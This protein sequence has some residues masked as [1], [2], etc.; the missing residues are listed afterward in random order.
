MKKAISIDKVGTA[1]LIFTAVFSPCCFPL[2]AF[3]ATSFGLGRFELFG[4]YSILIFN[5]MVIITLIGL[6]ISFAKH[7]CLY[8]LLVAVPGALVI[9]FNT[10]I[11]GNYSDYLPYIGM[12]IILF[13]VILNY[14]KNKSHISNSIIYKSIMSC[15]NC[16]NTKE[17]EMPVDSCVYFYE[18][19]NCNSRLK[20]LAGDCCV[21]CSYGSV[22]C[23]PIQSHV[24]CC[25]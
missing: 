6:A 22:K 5:V 19:D 1:G 13:A 25:S 15:P 3:I 20:P 11:A 8:P 10:V 23:P 16:K 2:F 14:F 7:R 9:F 17:E 21:Y 18:C 24:P 12:V 4:S